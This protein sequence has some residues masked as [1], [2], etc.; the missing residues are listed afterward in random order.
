MIFNEYSYQEGLSSVGIGAWQKQSLGAMTE[1]A[2][3][4]LEEDFWREVESKEAGVDDDEGKGNVTDEGLKIL[5]RNLF[6]LIILTLF[7]QVSQRLIG[8]MRLDLVNC[9][10]NGV[11][12]KVYPK[13]TLVLPS[14]N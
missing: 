10:S 7:S 9:R 12:V 4:L 2:E 6:R 8:S 1:M 5:C 11:W 3:I 13:V 14:I